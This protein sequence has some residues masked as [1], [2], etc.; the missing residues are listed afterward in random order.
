MVAASAA[1]AITALVTARPA[2]AE[3]RALCDPGLSA[4]IQLQQAQQQQSAAQQQLNQIEATQAS[5]QQKAQQ[6]AG[7]VAQ[8][9]AAVQAQ[10][11]AI[12][13]TQAQIAE[14]ERNERYT[15]ASIDRD[16]ATLQVRQQLVDEQVRSE[17]ETDQTSYLQVLLTAQN[18]SEFVNRAMLV[19]K[20][21][22]ANQNLVNQVQA[23]K[24]VVQTQQVK[25]QKQH[26]QE[27]TLLNQ[28]VQEEV[29]LQAQ[30]ATQQQA[31]A[32]QQQL[33]NQIAA[34]T[35]Q[36]QQ[37]VNNLQK[38]INTDQAN[39]Q[40][41]VR[42]R[43]I[44]QEQAAAAAAARAAAAAAAVSVSAPAAAS[45]GGGG[46]GGFLTRN[47]S[48]AN[49]YPWGQCTYY[50]ATIYNIPGDW[51]NADTWFPSAQAAGFA[52]TSRPTAGAV[53]V[54]GSGGGYS[55]YGHVGVVQSVQGGTF[56][57]TEMNFYG[58]GIVD[59]RSGV[60]MSD[61]EGFIL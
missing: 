7:V 42:Q 30:L 18:F 3:A 61:V 4:C 9:Q 12:A 57:V 49:A 33:V 58:V 47:T 11:N 40:A 52:T 28:Q 44:Q 5:A 20:L 38:Q 22:Q 37:V 55:V 26:E 25:L 56:T 1:F 46:G 41:Q 8:A 32:K 6:I 34:Q 14:T 48:G 19:N 17:A 51:G 39:Y 27:T 54:W 60:S 50:V 2:G 24:T 21:I 31:L 45:S 15:Q 16:Q 23:A 43:Q 13:Q 10:E 35:A 59:T 53:V 29:V 36:Q